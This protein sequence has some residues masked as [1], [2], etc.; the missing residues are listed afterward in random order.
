MWEYAVASGTLCDDRMLRFGIR[1]IAQQNAGSDQTLNLRI[2]L[3]D[4]TDTVNRYINYVDMQ[5][6]N[7]TFAMDFELIA[8]D[9]VTDQAF[10]CKM[11][12]GAYVAN[13]RDEELAM[14]RTDST[15]LDSSEDITVKVYV[16]LSTAST[17]YDI[18]V[19]QSWVELV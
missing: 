9:S 12:R 7:L 15:E 6:G 19:R 10:F 8:K 1:G 17:G 2:E 14:Q 13:S 3:S 18:R 16:T 11:C 5:Q 4:G